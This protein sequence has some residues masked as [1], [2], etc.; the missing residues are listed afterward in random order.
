MKNPLVSFTKTIKNDGSLDAGTKKIF[1]ARL[2]T[3]KLT[4]SDDPL[5]HFCSFIVPVHRQSRSI[6]AGH[7][8]KAN[9]WIPPGGHIELGETPLDT[10]R[11]EFNEELSYELTNQKIEFFD[12]SIM[13]VN[14][15]IRPCRIHNDFWFA[16]YMNSMPDFKVDKGEFYEASW[17]TIDQTI[18][19]A[20]RKIVIDALT[21]LKQLLA[22][23]AI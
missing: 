12:I 1:L 18:R 3:G 17:L 16:I 22:S 13:N 2:S 7:H 6:F 23:H 20:R 10:V 21:H 5:N 4:K 14:S 19:R 8:I 15:P 11:R 9:E